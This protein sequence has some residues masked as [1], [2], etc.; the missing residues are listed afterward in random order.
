MSS[1][2]ATTTS[3]A[4]AQFEQKTATCHMPR[5]LR[6]CRTEGLS[7]NDDPLANLDHAL[8]ANASGV[9]V[10]TAQPLKQRAAPDQELVDDD[11]IATLPVGPDLESAPEA[12]A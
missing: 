3:D 7:A 12:P 9:G 2:S 1:R 10:R 11:V 5:W 4:S 8:P 6:S